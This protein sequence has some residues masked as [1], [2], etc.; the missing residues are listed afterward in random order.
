MHGSMSD[1]LDLTRMEEGAVQ[2]DAEWCP[3]YEL[4]AEARQPLVALL[5]EHRLRVQTPDDAIVWCDPRLMQQ[6]LANLLDNAARHTPAGCTITVLVQV[7]ATQWQL[8]VHDDG[9]GL[10]PGSEIDVF[11]KFHRFATS[12][13]RPAAVPASAWRFAPRSRACTAAASKRTTTAAPA[14]R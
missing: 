5:R 12:T 3:A 4:V 11:K 9:P 14:S 13:S 6:A 10:P 7:E 1:L 8:Q 2:P